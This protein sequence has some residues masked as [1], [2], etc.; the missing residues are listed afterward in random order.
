MITCDIRNRK[1]ML[2]LSIVVILSVLN[3]TPAQSQSP[4]AIQNPCASKATCHECIQTQACAWCMQP[5]FGKKQRCFQPSL[6]YR[7]ME[8]QEEWIYNP[9]NIQ[10]VSIARQL[11]RTGSM[12][13]SAAAEYMEMASMYSNSSSSSWSSGSSSSWGSSAGGGSSGG[14]SS[15]SGGQITQIYPQ[16][17]NLKLRI[18]ME[19]LN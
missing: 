11:T 6:T 17:V 15:A 10:M 9:D 7:S 1:A 5:D 18:S 3:I 2:V 14:S 13:G 19:N 12:K 8:C 16:R 4:L